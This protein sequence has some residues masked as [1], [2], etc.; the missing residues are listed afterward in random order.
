MK[1]KFFNQI[2]QTGI[3]K[4]LRH[5]KYRL[6]A[7][8]AGL[9]YLISPLDISPDFIPFLGW[10]DDGLI[11]SF[12]VAEASQILIEEMKKRKKVTS[13]ESTS[14]QTGNTIDVEAVTLS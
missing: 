12:V 6:F 11:A 10:V 3:R 13:A 4:V 9:F 5:P 2:F 8:V 14:P 1:K 7:I